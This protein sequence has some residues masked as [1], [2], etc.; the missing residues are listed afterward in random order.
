MSIVISSG[1]LNPSN[2][3][4]E[5]INGGDK[6][7]TNVA[8]RIWRDNP[9]Y[10]YNS[11]LLP[12]ADE[13]IKEVDAILR[14]EMVAAGIPASVTPDGNAGMMDMAFGKAENLRLN[15]GCFSEVPSKLVGFVH[16]WKF[17]RAWYYYRA[18]GPGIP[19]EFAIPFDEKWGRQVRVNGDCACRGAAFWGDGF[20]IGDYH[21]DTPAGL[22]AFI[23]LLATIHKPHPREK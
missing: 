4:A 21:I 20:A 9:E 7:F 10:P 14:A 6:V 22:K 17:E 8:R 19:P 2:A 1:G 18:E 5:N 3:I 11:F 12:E 16:R 13:I 23:E 15:N